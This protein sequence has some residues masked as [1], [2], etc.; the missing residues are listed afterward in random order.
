MQQTLFETAKPADGT[1]RKTHALRDAPQLTANALAEYLV[2]TPV[3]RNAIVRASKFPPVAA[4]GAYSGARAFLK[5]LLGGR[6]LDLAAVREQAEA[7]RLRAEAE[8]GA[9]ARIQANLNADYLDRVVALSNGLA[10][11]GD[12]YSPGP[13]RAPKLQV[14]GVA[15]S[16]A[17]DLLVYARAGEGS[18]RV[19]AA[20]IRFA[21]GREVGA[22]EG[23]TL[24]ALL[25]EY[26]RLNLAGL[27]EADPG[28]SFV[29]D[30]ATGALHHPPRAPKAVLR[31]VAA[32]CE[33][34]G[35]QWPAVPA[36]DKA[37]IGPDQGAGPA[38]SAF[39]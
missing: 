18:Y 25:H 15:V 28:L 20:K 2:A 26:A 4:I 10:L 32:V 36:P 23:R 38:R 6:G 11:P 13:A 1:G 34:I 39:K 14:G 22:E 12:F 29:L 19:G 24:A 17:P 35:Q 9:F 27:G 8:G 5:R 3:R 30:L 37:V 16:V 31:D 21:K 33:A 7:Y